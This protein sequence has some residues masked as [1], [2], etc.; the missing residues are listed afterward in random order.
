M[1]VRALLLDFDGT[2][3]DSLPALRQL[4]E[5]FV[6]DLGGEPSAEEF[7]ALN[8][9]PLRRVVEALCVTHQQR[10]SCD[11]DVK[12]YQQLLA[13]EM[14]RVAPAAEVGALFDAADERGIQCAIVTSNRAD[15]VAAWIEANGLSRRCGVIVSGEEVREGKPSP[16]PYLLA[17]KRLGLRPEQALAIE[18][19]RSG[20]SSATAAGIRTLWLT[21]AGSG[22]TGVATIDS[23][24]GAVAYLDGTGNSD[25]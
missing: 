12:L 23:L 7:E 3:A 17:L 19:S 10:P 18:D 5:R 11:E 15:L 25:S 13:E 21:K 9:P 1:A 24:G 14:L 4:Y 16:E 2:L 22:C 20:V 6:S 8:G